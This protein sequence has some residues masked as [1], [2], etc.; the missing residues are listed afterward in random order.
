MQRF[1]CLDCWWCDMFLS[2]EVEI[3]FQSKLKQNQP[4]KQ[5]QLEPFWESH[6]ETDSRRLK[7]IQEGR[8]NPFCPPERP[9][10]PAEPSNVQQCPVVP[11]DHTVTAIAPTGP[12]MEKRWVLGQVCS[13]DRSEETKSQE[14]SPQRIRSL[15]YCGNEVK[16]GKQRNWQ[17][18]LSAN[19]PRRCW[20]NRGLW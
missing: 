13:C 12:M 17:L 20:E 4:K 9:L 3:I 11:F 6:R 19:L 8:R 5:T 16:E 10:C 2:G 1:F 7:E 14:S 15:H 18:L